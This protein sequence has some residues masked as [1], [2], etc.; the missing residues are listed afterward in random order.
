MVIFE[1]PEPPD[2]GFDLTGLRHDGGWGQALY[3]CPQNPVWHAEGDVGTHTEMVCTE[4]VADPRFRALDPH[5]RQVLWLAA[6]LHDVAKPRTTRIVDGVVRQPG[7][8]RSGARLARRLLW[9]AGIDVEV[10]EAVC[11]LIAHHQ[12][13]F[14]LVDEDGA[15]GRVI[16]L[17]Q[18]LRCDWLQILAH[19]DAAGRECADRARIIEQTELFGLFCAEL[20]CLSKPWPFATDAARVRCGLDANRDPLAPGDPFPAF[21]VV[22]MSGL[23]ASGK[24]TWLA[25]NRP[26]LPIVSLDRLRQSMSIAPG[27]PQGRVVQ[28]AREAA[29]VHLRARRPFAW[30]AT[31]L[32]V[33]RRRWLV[34]LAVDYGAGVRLVAC[35]TTSFSM[36]ERNASRDE[37]VPRRVIEKMIDGWE[38][39]TRLESHALVIAQSE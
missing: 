1:P 28:A 38:A 20:Q 33:D 14:W 37:P 24:S 36:R 4:L 9:E 3:S 31:N 39:P 7:H 8:S 30:D 23:P 16:R 35:E 11:A 15:R 18:V 26:E 12:L 22:V 19:A 5:G 32:R 10:R 21:E 27:E 25:E 17:S 29:R 2:F 6:L 34:K 13:P